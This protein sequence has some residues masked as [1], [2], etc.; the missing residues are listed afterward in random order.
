MTTDQA[1]NYGTLVGVFLVAV[2][3]QW[4]ARKAQ[5]TASEAKSKTDEIHTLVNGG[6]TQDLT[7]L[8]ALTQRIADITQDP[9]DAAAR[10]L[11]AVNLQAHKDQYT[12]PLTIPTAP[13]TNPS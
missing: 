13:P 6:R 8:F 1:A 10:D 3:A 4:N 11:A 9:R 5:K 7:N 12:P 2:F